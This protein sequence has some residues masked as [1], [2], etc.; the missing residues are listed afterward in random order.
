M[1]ESNF[2][3]D[4]RAH[5]T[6]LWDRGDHKKWN[7]HSEQ[8][9]DRM[10][11]TPQ[12]YLLHAY[13]D[14]IKDEAIYSP[15]CI[16]TSDTGSGFMTRWMRSGRKHLQ[17]FC[18]KKLEGICT[19]SHAGLNI[20]RDSQYFFM[21]PVQSKFGN[22]LDE[23]GPLEVSR[24]SCRNLNQVDWGSLEILMRLCLALSWSSKLSGILSMCWLLGSWV[25]I[26]QAWKW[27]QYVYISYTCINSP[28]PNEKRAHIST[29]PT[30]TH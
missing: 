11:L 2:T 21:C 15:I 13:C 12:S 19:A 8:I 9:G 7:S 18:Q 5:G 1:R 24:Y 6:S 30:Q 10:L 28:L 4:P 27:N 25:E 23:I 3:K 16:N 20:Y 17:L 14:N 22:I 29:T 26:V